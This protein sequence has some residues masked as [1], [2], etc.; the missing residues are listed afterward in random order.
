[1]AAIRIVAAAQATSHQWALRPKSDRL[2]IWIRRT[3]SGKPRH[4]HNSLKALCMAH[5]KINHGLRVPISNNDIEEE[6]Q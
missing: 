6:T 5:N 3:A 2:L 1:M 4:W